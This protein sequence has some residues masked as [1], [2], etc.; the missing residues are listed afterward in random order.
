MSL[1]ADQGISYL[2]VPCPFLVVYPYVI[3]R[4]LGYWLDDP[5]YSTTMHVGT[6]WKRL[7]ELE[8]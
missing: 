2:P 1:N 4:G 6:L 7:A 3:K 5:K 8:L